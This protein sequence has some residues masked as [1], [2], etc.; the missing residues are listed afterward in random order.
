MAQFKLMFAK[1]QNRKRRAASRFKIASRAKR[2]KSSAVQL[3]MVRFGKNFGCAALLVASLCARPHDAKAQAVPQTT[4]APIP[5][6]TPAPKTTTTHSHHKKAAP[7]AET[8]AAPPPPPATLEQS[9]PRP[10]NVSFRNGQLTISS[11]NATL[12]QVLRAVQSQ[13]G[14]SMEIPASA[15]NERV[16]AQLGPGQAK[17]I[18]NTLLNGSKFDYMILGVAG[19]PGAVQK[20]ILTTRQNAPAN[21][22]NSAQNASPAQPVPDE[23]PQPEEPVAENTEYQNPDQPAPPPGG[24]RRPMMPGQPTQTGSEQPRRS[25]WSG[26]IAERGQ[27][28]G[29]VDAG[30]ATNAAA[31]AAIP[32]A[33][34]SCQPEWSAIVRLTQ[35]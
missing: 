29:T 10:P 28:A 22:V 32:A 20:V 4:T 30:T 24:F 26:R 23:E 31:T 17:D 14:A 1:R 12:A 16:V 21:G 3:S 9:P 5:V 19:N 34:E 15:G 33:T 18:L 2:W 6:T 7:A 8:P 11:T 35:P 25:F 27:D 13:T